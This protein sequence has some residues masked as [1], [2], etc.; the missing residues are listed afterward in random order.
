MRDVNKIYI[1]YDFVTPMGYVPFTYNKSELE[2]VFK[3]SMNGNLKLN[4]RYK[5]HKKIL[6]TDLT[7]DILHDNSNTLLIAIK[8]PKNILEG[9]DIKNII[10]NKL[11]TYMEIYDNFKVM[12]I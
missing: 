5:I 11:K 6:T 8:K 4:D 7:F 2:D 10:S 1:I 12:H 9:V 3:L